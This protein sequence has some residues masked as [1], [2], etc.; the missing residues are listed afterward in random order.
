MID[1]KKSNYQK[2][3]NSNQRMNQYNE[4]NN[5]NRYNITNKD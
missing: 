3:Y 5:D 4:R 1:N 2:Y